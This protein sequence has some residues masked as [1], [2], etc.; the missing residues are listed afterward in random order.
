MQ[1]F[2]EQNV[3]QNFHF[4]DPFLTANL[5]VEDPEIMGINFYFFSNYFVLLSWFL[6]LAMVL[7]NF[8]PL[9]TCHFAISTL[10][11][12]EWLKNENIYF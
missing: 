2:D 10:P 5:N 1:I 4:Y 7:E 11:C 12:S 9:L 8:F 3:L 6:F